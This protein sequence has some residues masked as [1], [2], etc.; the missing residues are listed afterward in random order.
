MSNLRFGNRNINFID[1]SSSLISF[2]NWFPHGR[3][4][5]FFSLILNKLNLIFNM[6]STHIGNT[7]NSFEIVGQ[8]TLPKQISIQIPKYS[9]FFNINANFNWTK[10]TWRWRFTYLSPFY[11]FLLFI[12]ICV[13]NFSSGIIK[14]KWFLADFIF[15]WNV[16]FWHKTYFD[17][18]HF[19]FQDFYSKFIFSLFW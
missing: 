19:W 8:D 2:H 12:S 11:T 5:N 14:T 18:I 16:L 4:F 1:L 15:N 10:F 3:S 13:M 9:L 6:N 17:K 7:G